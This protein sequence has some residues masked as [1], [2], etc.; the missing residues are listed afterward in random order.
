MRGSGARDPAAPAC[1]RARAWPRRSPSAHLSPLPPPGT[2]V[3]KPAQDGMSLPEKKPPSFQEAL[4]LKIQNKL[5]V[6]WSRK[7]KS[8]P[9]CQE[10]GSPLGSCGRVHS[11][12]AVGVPTMLRG[13]TVS[14][15]SSSS[16]QSSPG[17]GLAEP[18][19]RSSPP[20][21][22]KEPLSCSLL[23]C[24]HI[25]GP[26]ALCM[27]SSIFHGSRPVRPSTRPLCS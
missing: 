12:R 17:W 7:H 21:Q 6:K 11:P 1:G 18:C 5:H 25:P 2:T 22:N 13:D 9:R 15:R 4:P 24:Q 14:D 8:G 16:F 20:R 23:G 26:R 27:H 10:P 3:P 19:R